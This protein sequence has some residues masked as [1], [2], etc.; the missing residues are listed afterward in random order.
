MRENLSGM[1][2]NLKQKNGPLP[3][4][5]IASYTPGNKVPDQILYPAKNVFA[6]L[7]I[8]ESPAVLLD[9]VGFLL[10]LLTRTTDTRRL[11][12]KFFAVQIQI[13]IQNKCLG[14]GY[15]GLV[16]CRNN[17][18]IME[19]MD[20]GITVPK[21]VLIVWPKIPQMP[22]KFSAQLICPSPKFWNFNEKRLQWTSV[23]P[24][25]DNNFLK[26]TFFYTISPWHS[27]CLPVPLGLDFSIQNVINLCNSIRM[28]FQTWFQLPIFF[29]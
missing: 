16:F 17:C 14:C 5:M 21:W 6:G 23:V 2:G 15:K 24:G 12:S 1:R 9:G 3:T 7:W 22:Q 10:W 13:P 26:L 20:K 4:H 19:N 28:E 18:W 11:N 27:P 29:N 8:S 25:L